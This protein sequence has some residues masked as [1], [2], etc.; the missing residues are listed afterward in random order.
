MNGIRRSFVE[1][2]G[3][4]FDIDEVSVGAYVATGTDV[5]GRKVETSGTDYDK[6]LDHCKRLAAEIAVSK[7]KE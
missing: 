7:H 2:P 3:W 6:V 4:T 1:F 5:L